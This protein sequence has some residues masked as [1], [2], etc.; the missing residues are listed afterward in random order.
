MNMIHKD[1]ITWLLETVNEKIKSTGLNFF[2]NWLLK[3]V[4]MAVRLCP[5]M[6]VYVSKNFV[7][8]NAPTIQEIFLE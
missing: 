6:S 8:E 1:F 4:G 5:R 2:I 7:F 3:V